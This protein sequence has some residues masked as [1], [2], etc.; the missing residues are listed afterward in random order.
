MEQLQAR[1]VFLGQVGADV[2]GTALGVVRAEGEEDLV[3][4]VGVDR[5]GHGPRQ[6][7]QMLMGQH[8]RQAIATRLGQHV[9]QADGQVQEVVRLVDI[10]RRVQP[11]F[12]G[13]LGP[14]GGGLPQRRQQQQ[15]A[16]QA[17]GVF[18]EQSLG[19]A[20]QQ[21]AAVK[22]VGRVEA[23]DRGAE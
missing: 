16:H 5:F 21:D 11:L 13:D 19:Q 2:F 12:L 15:R 7:V 8:Q 10:D 14:A 4:R 22:D 20:G 17:A 18:A 23:G 3:A 6:L 9:F 1:Q